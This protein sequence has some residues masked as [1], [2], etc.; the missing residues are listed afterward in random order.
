MGAPFADARGTNYNN[1]YVALFDGV[2]H[3]Q[4]FRWDGPEHYDEM[5]RG[6]AFGD[7]SGDGTPDIMLGAGSGTGTNYGGYVLVMNGASFGQQL[8][9]FTDG[10]SHVKPEQNFGF[11]VAAA[12]VDGDGS[13]DVIVGAYRGRSLPARRAPATGYVR[14]YSGADGALLYQVNGDNAGDQFG[15]AL[16]TADVTGDGLADVIVGA[17]WGANGG[18]VRVFDGPTGALVDEEIAAAAFDWLGQSVAGGDVDLNG[19]ANVGAGAYQG[20]SRS[21]SQGDTSASMRSSVRAA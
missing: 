7:V 12:D 17:R 16:A 4:L 10:L 21:A 1:G 14:V 3:A 9:S 11:A 13:S 19:Q 18:Y 15:R 2:T 8:Y 5:G 20:D 6:V